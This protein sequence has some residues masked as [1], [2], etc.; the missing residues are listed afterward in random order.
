MQRER[1]VADGAAPRQPA[2]AAVDR[3]RDAAAV[4][5][6]DRL[7]AVLDDPPELGEQRGRQRVA[8]LAAKVDEPN[9]RHRRADP[10][11]ERDPL[12]LRPALGARGRAAV[13]RDGALERGAL[14]GHGA[15]VVARIGLLLEGG[16][17]LLVD[18]DSPRPRIGAN[19]AERAPTTIA[20]LAARDPV[21]LV[22]PL[23]VAER[24][25]QDRDACRRSAAGSGR[26]SAG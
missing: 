22:A 9:R 4:E 25:V 16:V 18:D 21:A 8:G 23:G 12:E 10:H 6:Q 14:R 19:T 13:D 20:R 11:R 17:V 24:R 2:G 15:R 3:R 5:Q 1:D 26:P 7:A